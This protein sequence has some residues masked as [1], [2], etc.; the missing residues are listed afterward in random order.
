VPVWGGFKTRP[1]PVRFARQQGRHAMTRP[2]NAAEA[3]ALANAE[4]TRWFS[5]S[6]GRIELAITL[7][8][9]KACSH[10][11]RC[12]DDVAALLA[13]PYITEQLARIS[14]DTL[15]NELREYG[16]WD[17]VELADRQQNLARLL[18]CA[19][20]DIVENERDAA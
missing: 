4:P 10:S 5:S 6:S 16:A 7:D 15:A 8:D 13:V 1:F 12:D 14:S 2:N 3:I 20:G 18:W 19:C 9:A 17:E 11:G